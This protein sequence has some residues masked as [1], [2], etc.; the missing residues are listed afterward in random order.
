MVITAL[1]ALAANAAVLLAAVGCGWWAQAIL[2]DNASRAG[3]AS[4]TL[5]TG[6]GLLSWLLFLAGQLAF[7]P[8][9]VFAIVGTAGLQPA[10][11]AI[12]AGKGYMTEQGSAEHAFDL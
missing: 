10:L 6:L 1:A 5:V 8:A 4:A 3:R 7:T 2:P 9:V 12:R 11:A